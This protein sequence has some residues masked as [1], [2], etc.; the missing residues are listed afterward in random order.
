[1]ANSECILNPALFVKGIP[2]EIFKHYRKNTP[3]FQDKDTM[4]ADRTVWNLVRYDDVLAGLKN[5]QTFSIQSHNELH[6]QTN[7]FGDSHHWH[8]KAMSL[9]ESPEHT[10]HKKRFS[11]IARK[12][13]T[14]A[15]RV[16]VRELANEFASKLANKGEID[17]VEDFSAILTSQI[18]CSYFNI[19]TENHEYFRRLSS[20]FM[21]DTL[22]SPEVGSV[23]DYSNKCPFNTS[24]TSPARNA[25]DMIKKYWGNSHWLEETFIKTADRWEV[26]DLGLQMFSAGMAGLRNC[27]TMGVYYLALNWKEL[28]NSSHLWLSNIDLI[29]EEVIRLT[30]PLMRIRRVLS[31]DIEMYG[32]EMKKNDHVFLWLVS[33]NTDPSIFQNPLQ[34][35]PF[36]SPNPHLS[37]SSG[38]HSC[39]GFSLARMEVEEVL[40]SI[41]INWGK[42]ELVNSPIRFKSS[43]VNEISSMKIRIGV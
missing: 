11:G 6:E 34:F 15:Y 9:L 7:S 16:V 18:V 36:R 3:L 35:V 40:K 27:I 38:I 33:A 10:I 1:M 14:D 4:N 32:Q 12:A 28:K 30:T 25:M 37:F 24:G 13:N 21:G 19:P 26:E 31:S 20:V 41:I 43:V 17:A 2:Y 29:A 22:L 39:L 42:L 8:P 23:S 5:V